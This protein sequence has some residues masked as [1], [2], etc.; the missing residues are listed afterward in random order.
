[1]VTDQFSAIVGVVPMHVIYGL[2]TIFSVEFLYALYD[3][4]IIEITQKSFVISYQYFVY[5]EQLKYIPKQTYLYQI[6]NETSKFNFTFANN[7]TI[8]NF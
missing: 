5:G 4:L 1:M 3:L 8:R 2:P 7:K 6:L